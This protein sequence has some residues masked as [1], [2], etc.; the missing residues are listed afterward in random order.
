V[1]QMMVFAIHQ[2]S[3]KYFEDKINQNHCWLI[4]L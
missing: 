4:K 3:I 2:V 1:D